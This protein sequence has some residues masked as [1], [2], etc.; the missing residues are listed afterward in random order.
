[1]AYYRRVK[2]F[3]IIDRKFSSRKI[4]YFREILNHINPAYRNQETK[5]FSFLS[6]PEI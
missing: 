4:Q 1:M 6:L 2:L 5:S 3:K